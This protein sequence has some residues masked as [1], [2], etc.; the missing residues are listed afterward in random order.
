VGRAQFEGRP[1][2][3]LVSCY[4]SEKQ[5]KNKT[6]QVEAQ[7]VECLLKILDS[8]PSTEKQNQIAELYSIIFCIS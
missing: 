5:T 2:P 6:T 1:L 4:L 8:T 3:K 7:V